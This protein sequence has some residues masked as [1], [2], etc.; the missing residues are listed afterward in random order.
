MDIRFLPIF[1]F[2]LLGGFAAFLISVPM[3]FMLGGIF[4]AAC[5]VLWYERAE[6]RLPKLS[7]WVRL[8]FMSII[9]A[10]IGSRFSPEL[11]TLL[12]QF[13]ISGLAL[14]PFI[15][16]AHGGSYAIMRGLGGYEKLDAYFAALPG[17]IIDSTAL[18]EEAGADLRIVTAQHFIRIILV[19][20]SVPLLFLFIKGDA[21]GSLAG[22]TMAAVDYDFI[23]V[24]MIIS[25]ALVG[26]FIGQATRLPVSHMLGPLLLALALSV[27]GVVVIDIP[28]WLGH[29]AQYMVG[30]ALGAQF[31]GV[32]RRLLIRGLGMGLLAGVY[33]LSLAAGFAAVL[34]QFVP[35]DFGAMF[36]SFA[37]GGL[38]E[39]SLIALSLNFNPVVV[40]IHHL[41]RILMT[42][43]FG[44]ILSRRVFKLLPPR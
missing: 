40:A 26:L 17:G 43:Y 31:S 38:A 15:L 42:V 19:V 20:S 25:I 12:P 36:I 16:L 28:P 44:N 14:I 1:A 21:V 22:Q 32:S 3:P 13:W 23:D 5:F 6:K 34:V 24:A 37:A 27:G 10:M 4:G 41:V 9:G 33:M 7:R 11:L 29:A 30:T 2:G 18:A 8:V 35:A 39:M